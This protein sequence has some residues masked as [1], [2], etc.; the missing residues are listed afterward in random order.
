M[1]HT[2]KVWKALEVLDS[3]A[4]DRWWDSGFLAGVEGGGGRVVLE[5]TILLFNVEGALLG[6]TYTHIKH[7]TVSESEIL[8]TNETENMYTSTV[9]CMSY[10]MG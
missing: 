4:M 10:I 2:D 6:E 1:S 5:A 9:Q 8:C 7:G 3:D